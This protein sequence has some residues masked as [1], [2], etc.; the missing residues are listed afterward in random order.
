MTM[1][2]AYAGTELEVVIVQDA[3]DLCEVSGV[4][5]S[6][7]LGGQPGGSG[8]GKPANWYH[9]FGVPVGTFSISRRMLA[10]ADQGDAFASLIAGTSFIQQESIPTASAT[11]TPTFAM[12]SLLTI[13]YVATGVRLREGQD[14]TVNWATGVITFTPTLV[15]A[16][17]IAYMSDASG[18][19]G[20]NLLTNSNFEDDLSNVWTTNGVAG[21]TIAQET[22]AANVYRGTYS[23]KLTP[24]LI[25]GGIWHIPDISVR[26]GRVHVFKLRLKGTSADTMEA[27]WEDAA[28]FV[29]MSPAAAAIGSAV[30]VIKEWTFTPDEPVIKTVELRNTAAAPTA[31]YVDDAYLAE[32][33]PPLDPVGGSMFPFVF[34]VIWRRRSDRV[35]V[36]KLKGCAV[37]S[38]SGSASEGA[39]AATEDISGNFLSYEGEP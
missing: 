16:A 29:A 26:P 37:Y 6:I 30:F 34:D 7:D 15:A 19:R 24:T 23:A 35:T 38:S 18:M 22:G 36:R 12:Q 10:K 27:R 5:Y 2:G 8:L 1:Q 32:Q 3:L 39:D 21:S 28:G 33:S 11:Y 20:A 31:F 25:N 4:D 17:T 14:F 9:K 13:R